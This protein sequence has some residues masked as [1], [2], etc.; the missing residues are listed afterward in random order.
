MANER[1][2]DYREWETD[3]STRQSVHGFTK[4]HP[5]REATSTTASQVSDPGHIH[6]IGYWGGSFGGSS[7]AQVFRV[8]NSASSTAP[9][10]MIKSN[11]TGVGV[12]ATTTTTVSNA[13]VASGETR[14]RNVALLA[15]IKY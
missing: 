1:H 2:T 10:D 6:Q 9:G 13:G 5:F 7:G 12:T 8:D 4:Y 15:C 14:P 11:T 3:A